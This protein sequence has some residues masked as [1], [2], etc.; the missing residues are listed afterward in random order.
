MIHFICRRCGK[1][2]LDFEA[3]VACWKGDEQVP[4]QIIKDVKGK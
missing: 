2:Y 1:Q 3:L 4:Y